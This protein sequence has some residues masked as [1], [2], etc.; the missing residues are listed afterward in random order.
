MP[1]RSIVDTIDCIV[2]VLRTRA[3]DLN[4]IIIIYLARPRKTMGINLTRI[5]FDF[6]YSNA[7]SR[8]RYLTL[9]TKTRSHQTTKIPNHLLGSCRRTV[10]SL[11]CDRSRTP[12]SHWKIVFVWKLY[13][14]NLVK[15]Y[16]IGFEPGRHRMLQKWFQRCGLNVSR[17]IETFSFQHA[18]MSETEKRG[19]KL[20][21]TPPMLPFISHFC[22]SRTANP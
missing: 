20:R 3:C 17:R 2:T 16:R 18:L 4:W 15:P 5:Y 11:K 8:T 13:V 7:Q 12:S 22:H 21:S 19:I 10:T 14:R 9:N 1:I 6:Q